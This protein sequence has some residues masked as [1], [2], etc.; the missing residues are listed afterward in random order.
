MSPLSSPESDESGLGLQ[1]I[2]STSCSGPIECAS[3]PNLPTFSNMV[4]K[5]AQVGTSL[6]GEFRPHVS[7]SGGPP[8]TPV[9]VTGSVSSLS[10]PTTVELTSGPL[11]CAFSTSETGRSFTLQTDAAGTLLASTAL[12]TRT[13]LCKDKPQGFINGVPIPYRDPE[14]GPITIERCGRQ[15][16]ANLACNLYSL[17]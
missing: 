6:T 4:L 12:V 9:P 1:E 10:Y 5:L 13:V 8:G 16:G 2:S 11:P 17:P 14:P 15:G 7:C 3:R